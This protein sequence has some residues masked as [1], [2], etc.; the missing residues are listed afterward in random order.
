MNTCV[1]HAGGQLACWGA[2]GSRQLL[3]GTTTERL[4]PV[5][6]PGLTD[7]ADVAVSHNHICAVRDGG[8]ALC[9]GNNERGYLGTGNTDSR[10]EPTEVL[11]VA[12]AV[13]IGATRTTN[14]HT[15]VLRATGQALCFGEAP[16]GVLGTGVIFEQ[17]EPLPVPVLDLP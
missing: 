7:V 10:S 14:G 9:W 4:A 11:G 17:R 5:D 2:N 8:Q 6:L 3:D 1:I 16:Y 13:A 15:C 12:D